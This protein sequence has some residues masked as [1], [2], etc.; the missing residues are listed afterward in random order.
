MAI[1]MWCDQ[2]M[3]TGLSCSVSALHREG[4]RVEITRW[5]SEPG[6]T[7]SGRCGDC[8]TM[9]GGFHHLGCDVQR[10]ALCGDQM[11]SCG[12]RFDEDEPE[13]DD[14]QILE[15]YVDSN[16]CPTER[17]VR[18]GIEMIIHYDDVP[19]SDIT[20][21][22]GIRCTTAL[23]TVIDIAPD[24]DADQLE[25]AVQDGL[26][27]GLFTVDEARARLAQDDMRT[28]PGAALLR[29]VLSS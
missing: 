1:C 2:E 24:L 17:V 4:Q 9:P 22:D 8:G 25:R 26:D 7:A 28:R 23:R 20:T 11:S 19:E 21:V 27:R 18:N 14:A 6:W 3:T 12:C 15:T 16:G 29:Q 5:G 10:C 13:E